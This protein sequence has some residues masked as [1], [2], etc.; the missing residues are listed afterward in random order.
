MTRNRSLP[1]DPKDPS[2]GSVQV[3]CGT[4]NYICKGGPPSSL[5]SQKFGPD[6][7]VAEYPYSPQSDENAYAQGGKGNAIE[8]FSPAQ[9]PVKTAM[10]RF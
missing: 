7:Q 5:W 3:T 10:V 2:K 4:A 6:A 9:L 1:I 8:M